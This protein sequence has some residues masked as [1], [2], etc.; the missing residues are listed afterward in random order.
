[1]TS[2]GDEYV[3]DGRYIEFGF[4]LGGCGERPTHF[5][6]RSPGEHYAFC[7]K[8]YDA[9]IK[10]IRLNSHADRPADQNNADT[11]DILKRPDGPPGA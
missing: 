8:H 3:C 1:M 11:P 10:T 6:S 4:C 5:V 2:I 7:D 9:Y